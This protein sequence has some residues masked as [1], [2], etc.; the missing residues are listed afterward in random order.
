MDK[1]A[2]INALRNYAQA[3]S[4]EVANMVAGPVDLVNTG[5]EKVG[6]G[7]KEPIGGSAW[8]QRQG[9][10]APVPEGWA[11]TLGEATGLVLP[12]AGAKSKE[13][14]QALRKGGENLA[15]SVGAGGVGGGQRG[16]IVWQGSPHKF[17]KFDASKIGTG[18]GAQAYGDGLYLAEAQDVGADY[19][20]RLGTKIDVNNQPLMQK[21]KIVGTT[22]NQELD[23]FLVANLGDVKA[24]KKDI[25]QSIKEVRPTNYEAAKDYQRLL[26]NLR[27]TQVDTK[28]A[29]YLYKVDLPD[30]HIAKMLDWDKPLS[31]QPQQTLSAL[32]NVA[33]QSKSIAEQLQPFELGASTGQSIMTALG[34]E[35]TP[36]G[37][38]QL[39]Q[40]SGIPGVR[41]LDGVSRGAGAGTSNFV[42]FPGNENLLTILERN[43]EIINPQLIVKALRNG[44]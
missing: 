23:D 5:L 37:A 4:N 33:K 42:V 10:T 16:A 31:Q 29:G 8:M 21:G 25:L 26:A 3:T 38:A 44:N 9:L 27:K 32:Q 11:Q 30:E 1:Q 34:N 40:K 41:Y 19:A 14:A 39:L 22:G 35:L 6:L 7:S 2:I 17:V 15:K 18:E 36:K 24:A 20:K 28:N 13:I 43:G 12:F